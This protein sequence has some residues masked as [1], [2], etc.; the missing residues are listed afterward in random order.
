LTSNT[1]SLLSLNGNSSVFCT[2]PAEKAVFLN[3]DGNIQIPKLNVTANTFVGKG[4]GIT[5]INAE[6]N[7]LAPEAP[8]DGETYARNNKT[9]VSISDSAGIPDA[10]VDGLQYGRQDGEWTEVESGTNGYTKAEIDAQQNAQDVNITANTNAIANLPSPVDTYTKA[11]I[12]ASQDAQ[13]VE[14]AKKANTSDT[15]T[16]AATDTL[17]DSKA[18]VGDSYT[19]A[20]T[21]SSV[22]VDGKLFEK[23]DKTTTYT[24]T[25]VDNS[26]DAQDTNISNNTSAIGTLSGRVSA[27]EQDIATLQDGIFFSSS[28]TTDYP[29]NPNRDPE[30]GNIY[31]QDLSAFTYS[32]ADANQVFISKTDEQGNVRQFTAVKPDDILVLNQ[33]ESPNYGRYKVSSVNDLGDYVNVIMDFQVGEGTV[34]EGDTLALQAF[35]ASEGGTGGGIPEAPIDGKQYGRQDATWTEVTGGVNSSKTVNTDYVNTNDTPLLVQFGL[36]ISNPT[37]SANYAEFLI[38]GNVFGGNG[39]NTTLG[40][41]YTSPS[42]TVPAGSTYQMRT[43]VTDGTVLVSQWREAKLPL[44]VATGGGSYTPESLVWEDKKLENDFDVLYTNDSDVPRYVEISLTSLEDTEYA[45]A[46]FLIDGKYHASMGKR[47]SGIRDMSQGMF[48]VPAGSTYN[49]E[50]DGNVVI[51]TWWEAKMPLAIGVPSVDTAIGMVAPFAM[52]S[53]PTGW[54]HC[55]GSAVSRDTYSLLYS[56]IGDT[57]GNGDGST[58]FNLPDLQDE[59][60]RGSSDT[61]PVG[62]KQDDEFKA[63]KH[64]QNVMDP[65]GGNTGD[66]R[67]INLNPSTE[68]TGSSTAIVGGEETRPRNV[69]MLYCINATA[70]SSSGGGGS[71][72]PEKME[73]KVTND[74]IRK[75]D[76]VYTNDSDTPRFVNLN[77]KYYYDGSSS[78]AFYIDGE[79]IAEMGRTATPDAQH[80]YTTQLFVVP[81][82][83]TYELKKNSQA[84]ISQWWEADMPVAS[85][86]RW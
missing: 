62:N 13:D 8:N 44:A 4:S 26:Q 57:Y 54:L 51:G 10:P 66:L 78:C 68:D 17:L 65:G 36:D 38:D 3:L 39:K 83:S 46:N 18:N 35:P 82:G 85:R 72:T 40:T 61:L 52:D 76:T 19:K 59:F 77:I 33:V 6:T 56:K 69:A 53:V 9:W 86:N 29:S 73:W 45:Y 48:I 41:T 49:L 74:P 31:L 47:G 55:D 11:E 2:Y 34:L 58:T 27:N 28:Y 15:Y 20:E 24:K 42:F 80:L 7:N 22:E 16:K 63:H 21:Y 60:I 84:N 71:Y 32:Y 5:N 43:T 79:E 64:G 75:F 14:I 37:G 67:T 50:K 23:A 1:G 25:E 70:E 30:T 81:S 12:N